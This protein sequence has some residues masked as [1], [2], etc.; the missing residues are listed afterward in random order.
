MKCKCPSCGSAL[1]EFVTLWATVPLGKYRCPQCGERFRA[2]KTGPIK[3]SSYAVGLAL[4]TLVVL[5]F[6]RVFPV[7]ALAAAV[8]IFAVDYWV[9][10]R[11]MRYF[12]L[13]KMVSTKPPDPE[14]E[15]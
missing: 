13:T 7:S 6:H 4:G 15:Q 3:Y 14:R 10:V 2:E 11:N 1:C 8:P 5:V 9:D 12:S